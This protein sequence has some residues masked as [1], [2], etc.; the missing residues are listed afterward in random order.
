MRERERDQLQLFIVSLSQG[1]NKST[2]RFIT[3]H[4]VEC[5]I[6]DRPKTLQIRL[7]IIARQK[8]I[9]QPLDNKKAK[10]ISKFF[11]YHVHHFLCAMIN[12]NCMQLFSLKTQLLLI[13]ALA[14]TKL[15]DKTGI[16]RHIIH[17]IQ[18]KSNIL[19]PI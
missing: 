16:I 17:H 12:S 7:T 13:K 10:D 18:I 3:T 6:Q 19:V 8:G 1:E 4:L 2:I 15:M 14:L 11:E 5:N 9:I